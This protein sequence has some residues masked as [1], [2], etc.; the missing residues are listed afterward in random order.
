METEGKFQHFNIK[1]VQGKIQLGTEVCIVLGPSAA[2]KTDQ[3]HQL[4][5]I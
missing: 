4:V 1:I 5:G 3:Y 2:I